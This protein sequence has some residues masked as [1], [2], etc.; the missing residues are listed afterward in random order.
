MKKIINKSLKE[1]EKL[2]NLASQ[3][4]ASPFPQLWL[5]TDQTEDAE[6]YK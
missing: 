2:L 1:S 5:A 3:H 6:N 4:W